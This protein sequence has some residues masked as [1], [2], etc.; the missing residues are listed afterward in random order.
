MTAAFAVYI[1]FMT[2]TYQFA[3]KPIEVGVVV[4]CEDTNKDLI[5]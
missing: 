2:I 1:L 5:Q 3:E 4:E